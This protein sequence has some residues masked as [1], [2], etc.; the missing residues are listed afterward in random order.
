MLG[1][2]ESG[3][4]GDSGALMLRPDAVQAWPESGRNVFARLCSDIDLCS[5]IRLRLPGLAL[6][7]LDSD[8]T[9]RLQLS[10]CQAVNT[11]VR[12]RSCCFIPFFLCNRFCRLHFDPAS[13]RYFW[14]TRW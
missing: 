9:G 2:S 11:L 4:G 12:R 10:Y 13:C 5:Y 6:Q 7:L 14:Q 8:T 1:C 3:I